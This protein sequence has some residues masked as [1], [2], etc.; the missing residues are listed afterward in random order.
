MGYI[1][2]DNEKEAITLVTF[3]YG[4]TP[5]Y[6]RY[7]NWSS[8]AT[9]PI[10]LEVFTSMVEMKVKLG[11]MTGM[12]DEPA[13]SVSMLRNTFTESISE[14]EPHADIFV[15]VEELVQDPDETEQKLLTMFIGKVRRCIRGKGGKANN[16]YVECENVKSRFDVPLGLVTGNHCPWMLGRKGCDPSG[17]AINIESLKRTGTVTTIDGNTITITGLPS[18]ATRYWHRGYVLFDGLPILIRDWASGDDFGLSLPPPAGWL[19][20]VVT[21]YPGCDKTIETCRSR[22]SNEEHFCGAGYAM[23]PYHPVFERP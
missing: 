5:T 1:L 23:P 19:G 16:V 9:H 21:V 10:S 18:V 4:D 3:M 13:S 7:T 14:A 17:T 8:D 20:K 15:T 6:V 12:F 11:K 22:W 2:G